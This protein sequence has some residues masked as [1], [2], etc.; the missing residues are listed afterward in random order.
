VAIPATSTNDADSSV[1]SPP[2]FRIPFDKAVAHERRGLWEDAYREYNEAFF[3][4]RKAGEVG[5]MLGS[6]LN[7]SRVLRLSQRIDAAADTAELAYEIAQAGGFGRQAARAMNM[8]AAI[9]HQREDWPGAEALYVRA[10]ELAR[11]D[12]DDELIAAISQNLG[13]IANARGRLREAQSLYLE[14]IGAA[15]RCGGVLTAAMIYNNLGMVCADLEEW[16]EA[17]ISFLRGAEIAERIGDLGLL[18]RLLTHRAE[19]LIRT[20]EF[21]MATDSLDRA[22]AL[23][24]RLNDPGALIDVHRYR[25]MMAR[26]RGSYG[27]ADRDLERAQQLAA[28]TGVELSRA[29][30]TEETAHLRL[31]Q[32][33]RGA[34]LLLMRDALKIFETLGAGRDAERVRSTAASWQSAPQPATPRSS[35]SGNF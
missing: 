10:L 32:G 11:D 35:E 2:P 22:A 23:A 31:A 25:G 5:E 21:Q 16:T 33:R 28:E 20:G 13:A 12:G 29:E 8:L 17:E 9:H 26:L 7:I 3:G 1:T 18:C 30:V 24:E 34:A 4:A 15:V 14:A 6:L 27:E 19:P